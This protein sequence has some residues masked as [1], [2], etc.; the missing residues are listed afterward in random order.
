M[1]SRSI[2]E[3]NRILAVCENSGDIRPGEVFG[4]IHLAEQDDR[5]HGIPAKAKI[6]CCGK[7]SDNELLFRAGDGRFYFSI[8]DGWGSRDGVLYGL[9]AGL[10]HDFQRPTAPETIPA[11]CEAALETYRN[12]VHSF[13]TAMMLHAKQRT[14]DKIRSVMKNAET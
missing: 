6:I 4:G 9:Q 14:L 2:T 11:E 8:C 1:L 5:L 7:I 3:K 12:R 13:N 10:F